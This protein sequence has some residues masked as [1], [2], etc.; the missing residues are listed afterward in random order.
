YDEKYLVSDSMEIVVQVNG[1]VRAKL[2]LPTSYDENKIFDEVLSN[3]RVSALIK[4]Q[5][6]V[7][8]IYIKG[9]LI[10]LVVK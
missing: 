9:K 2:T 5:E 8:K 10:S 6:L 4:D 3:E 7:K 1:K